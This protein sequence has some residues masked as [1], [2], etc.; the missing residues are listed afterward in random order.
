MT[1]YAVE[2]GHLNA[3]HADI[4]KAVRALVASLPD[5]LDC[6]QVCRAAAAI[7][8]LTHVRGHFH[9]KGWPHSWLEVPGEDV[10]IDAY[11]WAGSEPF[12]VSTA[13]MSPWQFVYVADPTGQV[14]KA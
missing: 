14:R 10:V 1:P 9:G 4:L 11:P 13:A 12:M 7:V 8:P 5:G 3:R 6:H 2:H